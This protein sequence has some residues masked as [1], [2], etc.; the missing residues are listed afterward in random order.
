MVVMGVNSAGNIYYA[1]KNITTS[2][3]WTQVP[4]GLSNLS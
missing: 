1:D 2:P 4:G 3:N